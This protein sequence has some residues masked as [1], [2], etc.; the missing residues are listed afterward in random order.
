MS[1]FA[2]F[3]ASF[4]FWNHEGA[5][6]IWLVGVALPPICLSLAAAF[7]YAHGNHS[8]AG[9]AAAVVYWV[10]IALTLMSA[11]EGLL[12]GAMLQTTAWFIS[13]PGRATRQPRSADATI[14]T[15]MP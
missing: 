1:T 11:L 12:L 10:V 7:Q 15:S 6:R 2:V 14:D 5:N 3:A 9:A 4:A 13:R 8:G